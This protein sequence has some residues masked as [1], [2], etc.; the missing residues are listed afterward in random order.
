MK[1]TRI[2]TILKGG[3]LALAALI[4]FSCSSPLLHRDAD[5]ESSGDGRT[6]L[7]LVVNGATIA[8]SGSGT[9][10]L[11]SRTIMA[12]AS[13]S[14]T[15]FAVR[16]QKDSSDKTVS[17]DGTTTTVADLEPGTW[18]VTVSGLDANSRTVASG[19]STV[20]VMA[21]LTTKT[22]VVV[23]PNYGSGSGAVDLSFSYPESV[24]IDKVTATFNGADV[25]PTTTGTSVKIAIAGQAAGYYPLAIQ[26]IKGGT[27]LAWYNDSVWVAANLTTSA[28][29]S[30]DASRFGSAPSIPVLTLT[31]Q[32][33]CKMLLSWDA[34]TTADS[35]N[36]ERSGSE[37]GAY[38]AIASNVS[39]TSYTDSTAVE[40]STY[41][42]RLT[43]TNRFGSS[44]SKVVSGTAVKSLVE[45]KISAGIAA[46]K[47]K[48]FDT[49]Y[50]QFKAAYEIDASSTDAAMWYSLM[51]I[52]AV[53]TDTNTVSL[54]KDRVGVVGYPSTMN[55]LFSTT[56]F[57][58]NWY[59][60][61]SGFV[62][63]ADSNCSSGYYCVRGNFT[64]NSTSTRSYNYYDSN[65]VWHNGQGDFSPSDSGTAYVSSWFDSST[66]TSVNDLNLTTYSVGFGCFY[67]Q[68]S[69]VDTASPVMLP[70]LEL[71]TWAETSYLSYLN[72]SGYMS[73]QTKDQMAAN[74]FTG[75]LMLNLITRNPDGLNDFV[76]TVLA[77]PFGD[78]LTTAL[79]L[80]DALP[81]DATLS[82]PDALI[83]A[84]GASAPS[85]S[86]VVNKAELKAVAASVRCLKS[87]VQ[88]LSSYNLNYPIKNLEMTSLWEYSSNTS[89]LPAW[90]I[91]FTEKTDNPIK[92]GFMGER[93]SSARSAAK[94]TM[95]AALADVQSAVTILGKN[96]NADY[97]GSLMGSKD[98]ATAD[99]IKML[100]TYLDTASSFDSSLTTSLTTGTSLYLDPSASPLTTN[101]VNQFLPANAGEGTWTI[102]PSVLY[103]T[104]YLNPRHYL[105]LTGTS[106]APTGLAI[107]GT[108]TAE[109][110][111]YTLLTDTSANRAT[112]WSPYCKLNYAWLMQLATPPANGRPTVDGDGYA[113][114]SIG[115]VILNVNDE[116]SWKLLNWLQN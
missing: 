68:G 28:V 34:C 97:L 50:T 84:Y 27:T 17:I 76:D 59:N 116:A 66:G 85:T 13:T 9:A 44:A 102:T 7:V 83:T 105:G 67:R 3:A 92:Y 37:A 109:P 56:W 23:S 110:S 4:S 24:G 36:L 57:N 48:D 6:K 49:A 64:A 96:M 62:K 87:F 111:K 54:L 95:L 79:A 75:V 41:Y 2:S 25:T 43:A 98:W 52:A 58:S 115:T 112:V 20:T 15:K 113:Y 8:S 70:R 88:L 19:S 86:I 5:A 14:V 21:N 78:R 82:V 22:N 33:G 69:I 114:V 71:P 40:G 80:I 107:Y 103:S 94:E 35:C 99:N 45:A 42:Y 53:S 18:T 93:S 11:T 38:T 91:S 108:T 106:D 16:L 12:D 104:D 51:S 90:L 73:G 61:K 55:E 65:N 29:K 89:G 46:L 101:G 30:L 47:S 74:S 39:G 1:N 10:Y 72:A 81:D 26:F 100:Q 63:V 32:N 77:G 31:P 60:T